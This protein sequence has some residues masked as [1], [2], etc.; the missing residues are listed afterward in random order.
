MVLIAGSRQGVPSV[1]DGSGRVP[2]II[3]SSMRQQLIDRFDRDMTVSIIPAD[4]DPQAQATE[5]L[6]LD[7]RNGDKRQQS[8]ENNIVR[9]S[10]TLGDVRASSSESDLLGAL[11]AGGRASATAADKTLYVYD[12]GVSTAGPLAMQN[13]LLGTGTDVSTIVKSLRTA[14]NIPSLNGVVVQWWALGQVAAPQS[15]LP[16]W[17]RTKLKELWT[18]VVEAGGGKVTFHDDAV[19]ASP[20]TGNLPKVTPVKFDNVQAKPVSLT[21]PE[22]Q[23]SFRPESADF[24]DAESAKKSLQQI[25][26]ILKDS[27]GETL[28]VTGCT[29]NPSGGSASRMQDLSKRRAHTVADALAKAGISTTLK[30]QGFGPACPGRSPETGTGAGLEASQAKNRLVL[31]TS[32]EL[33]PVPVQG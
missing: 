16:V 2:E 12:S 8:P 1:I 18:A 20:P 22:S 31:I 17:A 3:I 29:A 33:A 9:L 19:L 32:K 5:R 13:G 23:I 10:N 24:A 25:A 28:W 21:I 14:G 11:D 15:D 30:V 26:S 27:S 6:E 7:T 4:G